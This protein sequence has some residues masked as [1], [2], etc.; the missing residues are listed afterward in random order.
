MAT[1]TSSK[2][3]KISQY[4]NQKCRCAACRGAM[5]AYQRG[6]RAQPVP[7]SA[8]HGTE[9]TYTNRGCRCVP[10]RE[11]NTA[12]PRNQR[13]SPTRLDKVRTAVQR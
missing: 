8:V 10:C 11:A 2:H 7:A 13:R 4:T 1:E 5:A 9:N 12:S 6:R 3:G